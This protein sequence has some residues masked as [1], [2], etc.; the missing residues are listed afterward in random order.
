MKIDFHTHTFF[1]PDSSSPPEEMIEA[2]KKKG[3]QGLAITDHNEI[4][5][6]L[7]A[8]EYAKEKPFLIIPGIE[9][10]TKEGDMLGLNVKKN[11]PKGLSA[12]ETIKKIKEAGG[13][14]ILPHPFGLFQSFQG[15]LAGLIKEIDGIEVFNASI[16]GPGNKKALAFAQKHNLAFTAGS[17]AHSPES[18]GLA[19]LEIP[20][21]NLSVAEVLEA[22]KN[23]VGKVSGSEK[24]LSQKIIERGKRVRAFFGL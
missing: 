18:L 23:R 7:R 8:I 4:R 6:A 19:Y 13:I 11:I 24:L 15:N 12:K 22:I 16:F 20:G 17:D 3:I 14:A 1:S 21:E 5:G 9:V 2:A 10:K